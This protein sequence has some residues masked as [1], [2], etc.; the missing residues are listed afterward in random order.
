MWAGVTTVYTIRQ[1]WAVEAYGIPSST[2]SIVFRMGILLIVSGI[3]GLFAQRLSRRT[4]ELA[5]T[6]EQLQREEQWRSALINMLAHDFRG[7]VG[8][9]IS[10]ITMVDRQLDAL[11]SGT[12]TACS[13]RPRARAAADSHW[14]TTC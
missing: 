14:P 6:L 8:A 9:A 1:L 12:C 11:K 7:P 3:L 4:Q 13:G 5:E 2:S 10:T